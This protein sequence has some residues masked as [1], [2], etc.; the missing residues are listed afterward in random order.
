MKEPGICKRRCVAPGFTLIEVMIA[1]VIMAVLSLIAWRGLDSMG[2][3]NTQLQVRT[4]EA[5]RLMRALQQIERDLSW[6]TTVELPSAALDASS[7]DD[8]QA[9]LATQPQ[10]PTPLLPMGIEAR[11]SGQGPFLIELVRTA[12]AAPG[13]WLRVQWWLQSGTLYRAAGA[14]ADGYPLPAPQTADRVAVL[15]GIASFEMRAWEPEQG[16][17]PLPA[18]SVARAPASGI[19]VSLGIRTDAGPALRYRRVIALD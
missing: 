15:E 3:A 5:A 17:R 13:R 19:E 11:R 18:T 1:I 12:P 8:A 16:W 14:A 9:A 6:R 2:R 7:Q 10:I 4:E